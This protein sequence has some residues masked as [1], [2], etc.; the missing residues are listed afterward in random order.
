MGFLDRLLG[1]DTEYFIKKAKKYATAEDFGEALNCIREAEKIAKSDAEKS[2]IKDAKF[3]IEHGAYL[4]AVEQ[5][6]EYMRGH[7]SQNAQNAVDRAVRFAHSDD[8]K[9]AVRAIIDADLYHGDEEAAE[10]ELEVPARVE[11]EEHVTGMELQDK[12]SLYVT[13]LPFEKAQHF[14]E[15]G[16]NFKKAWIA[17]Q[18][19]HIDDAVTGLEEVYQS[20]QDDIDVSVE[21]GRAYYAKGDLQKASTLLQKADE[22]AQNNIDIKLLRAQILWT[23]KDFKTSEDVLQKAY[24]IDPDNNNVLASVAQQGLMTQEF[25]SAIAAVEQL[26][27][28]VPQDI[29]VQKLAARIYLESGDEEKALERFETVNRIYWKIDPQTK[30][31]TFDKNSAV[32]AASIYFKRGEKLERAAELLNTVRAN[33]QAEEHIAICMQLGEVYQK[34]EKPAKRTEV[35]TEA[36]RFVEEICESSKG[37]KH[38]NACLQYADICNQIGDK[39]KGADRLNEGLKFLDDIYEKASGD[40][41]ANLGLQYASICERCGV[42]ERG[43]AK[44]DAVLEHLDNAYQNAEGERRV[45]IGMQYAEIAERAGRK[46]DARPKLDE[47]REIVSVEANKGNPLAQFA[48]S[49]I[50]KRINGEE[51]PPA[52]EINRQQQAILKELIENQQAMMQSAQ[53]EAQADQTT[54]SSPRVAPM[55]NSDADA[56][57][58]S[59]ASLAPSPAQRPVSDDIENDDASDNDADEEAGNEIVDSNDA[60]EVADNANDADEV[61][62]DSNDAVESDDK[63]NNTFSNSITDVV[64]G[65]SNEQAND[66]LASLAKSFKD[67]TEQV[68]ESADSIFENSDDKKDDDALGSIFDNNND[69]KD[70]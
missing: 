34:M 32:A 37:D 41:R 11:G 13:N 22:A 60:D 18:E 70:E 36:L 30:K 10:T 7:M 68:T 33:T 49:M 56:L 31:I 21:L 14:D 6:K 43:Q 45:N 44:L 24:D 52:E 58:R 40:Q 28:N 15:L 9:N 2:S 66:L 35:L 46:D 16:D 55:N 61:A 57:L 19:G 59:F 47:A 3:D 63:D 1:H 20:H 50:E 62:D 5:A 67:A 8:E 27:E 29:S 17:L 64:S 23:L 4:L 69:K 26:I 39:D 54:I 48:L 51:L 25:E 42:K 38:A 65:M 12:W 53:E